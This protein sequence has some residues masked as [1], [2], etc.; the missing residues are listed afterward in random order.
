MRKNVI[1]LTSG[2][3]GS[4]VLTSLLARAGYWT[5]NG[6]FK[7][8]DYDTY[9]NQELID[10][11]KRLI[12]EAGYKGNYLVEFSADAIAAIAGLYGKIDPAPYISLLNSCEAH[13]P[14]IW[15]DPRLW[16]TIRYW[17]KFLDRDRCS[18]IL[19]TRGPMQSWISSTLR[20]QITSY[21]YS[22]RYEAQIKA[23]IEEVLAENKDSHLHLTYE[24]L[25]EQPAETI[26]RLNDYLGTALAVEDLQAI[27]HKPLYK[28]PRN[29]VFKHLKAILI[30]LKN[31]SERLDIAG[32][33]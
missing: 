19:L 24:E 23:S 27:Y 28:N 7:K 15:K 5:G 21:R 1:V 9:E 3:S 30:Y 2:L 14:W 32:E 10:L 12:Q 20:R 18:F 31:Y 11:N 29:S 26:G 8:R 17:R 13:A 22:K 16:L 25:I 6:T 33:R 4:S